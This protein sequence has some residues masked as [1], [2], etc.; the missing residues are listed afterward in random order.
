MKYLKRNMALYS[1]ILSV[2]FLSGCASTSGSTSNKNL[3][4]SGTS[5]SECYDKG[6]YPSILSGGRVACHARK[7]W[8]NVVNSPEE[9]Y[10][11]NKYPY[12]YY[13]NLYTC[14]GDIKISGD[15]TKIIYNEYGYDKD[16]YDKKGY[17]SSG[18]SKA[19]YK[20]D[21]YSSSGYDKAGYDKE[22]FNRAGINK[23]TKTQFDKHGYDQYGYDRNGYNKAGY[24]RPG[25]NKYGRNRQGITRQEIATQN[26]Q[27]QML[28]LERQRL[29]VAREAQ[30]DADFQRTMDGIRSQTEA[31]TPRTTTIMPLGGGMYSTYTN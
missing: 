20:K 12:K 16:G 9:C 3:S 28:A 11:I 1:V 10:K 23:Y 19:G 21:G 22:G 30:K 17:S 7:S 5:P 4:F 2:V 8:S 6:Y 27:Q 18:Y 14:V 24:D 13:H 15:F 25:F 26:Y 31:M 29:N